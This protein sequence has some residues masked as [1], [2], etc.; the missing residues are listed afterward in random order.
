MT[1]A[2]F[3]LAGT[4]LGVLGTLAIELVRSRTN[5]LRSRREA[6]RLAC[7]DFTAAVA[8]IWN[9][10]F[11]V[12][13]EHAT[14]E[15]MNSM[16]DTHR[17]AR[18]LYERLRLTAVSQDVQKA[19]RH[20]LRYAYGLLRQAE[21]K[22]LREDEQQ[23]GPLIMLDESLMSL[24]AAVRREIGMP[25]PDDVYQEPWIGSADPE[26]TTGGVPSS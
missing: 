2:I 10:S 23:R 17:E 13:S 16:R 6:L 9:L 11:E 18:V 5:D 24:Y 15:L 1:A 21:G 4:L 14:P 25:H 8:R 19:G 12:R 20:A 26:A 3:A 22:A 7:A